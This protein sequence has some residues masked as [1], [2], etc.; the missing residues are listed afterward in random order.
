MM[1]TTTMKLTY[2]DSGKSDKDVVLRLTDGMHG[3]LSLF[4]HAGKLCPI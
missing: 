2:D 4:Q 3:G 1:T